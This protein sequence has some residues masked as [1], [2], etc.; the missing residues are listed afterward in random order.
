MTKKEKTVNNS[1]K[2]HQM[3]GSAI[4]VLHHCLDAK[5]DIRLGIVYTLITERFTQT[6]YRFTSL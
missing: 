2:I 5:I 3:N 6:I 1:E 4:D